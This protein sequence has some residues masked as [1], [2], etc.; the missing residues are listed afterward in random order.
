MIVLGAFILMAVMSFVRARRF[1]APLRVISDYA[2]S[3]N[4]QTINKGDVEK[5]TK[6]IKLI[7]VS[8]SDYLYCYN[9]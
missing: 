4:V 6:P 2:N 1:L 9:S 5:E 3:K 7:D 8:R